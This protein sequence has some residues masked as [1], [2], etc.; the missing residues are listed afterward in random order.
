M[1]FLI[2]LIGLVILIGCDFNKSKYTNIP[3]TDHT[4]WTEMKEAGMDIKNHKLVYC[5][6]QGMLYDF[7]KERNR[8]ELTLLLKK[9]N[10]SIKSYI[11]SDVIVTG[12]TQGCYCGVMDEKI[13]ENMVMVLLI[14]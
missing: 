8:K 5:F 1:K 11:F 14:P 7:K 3:W 6:T 2:C 4:C 10:I 13:A 9:Y 12:Q